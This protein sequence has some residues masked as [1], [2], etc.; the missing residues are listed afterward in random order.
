MIRVGGKGQVQG[1]GHDKDAKGRGYGQ[2]EVQSVMR[3][4]VRMRVTV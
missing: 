1:E 3:A 2:E 4:T